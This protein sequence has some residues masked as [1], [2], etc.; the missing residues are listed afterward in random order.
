MK[1]VMC[2]GF[3]VFAMQNL[4]L[5]GSPDDLK[6]L[7][8]EQLRTISGGQAVAQ[9]NGMTLL[10]ADPGSPN[11]SFGPAGPASGAFI[12]PSAGGTSMPASSFG[13]MPTMGSIVGS[14][15]YT[16]YGNP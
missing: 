7:S 2:A 9:S 8:N 16:K 15:S 11:S 14:S 4:A 13:L 1:T 5:A 3:V 6:K 12:A 10:S